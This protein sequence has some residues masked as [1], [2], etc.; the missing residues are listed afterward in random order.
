ML[1]ISTEVVWKYLM[2]L[3]TMKRSILQVPTIAFL[4]LVRMI[5]KVADVGGTYRSAS[6]IS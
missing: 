1:L 3:Y 5:H 6:W 4:N 2:Y